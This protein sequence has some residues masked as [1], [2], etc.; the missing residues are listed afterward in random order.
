MG[1]HQTKKLLHSKEKNKK[2]SLLNER[3]YS[4]IIYPERFNI[5]N[6]LKTLQLIQLGSNNYE[7]YQYHTSKN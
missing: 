3:R 2:G 7:C 4:Q 5:Q 1:L 6:I